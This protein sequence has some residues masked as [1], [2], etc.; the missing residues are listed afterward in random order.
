LC[1]GVGALTLVAV[2]RAQNT[3]Q[4]KNKSGGNKRINQDIGWHLDF[5][6]AK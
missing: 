5:P 6:F 2:A 1:E 4:P 3:P